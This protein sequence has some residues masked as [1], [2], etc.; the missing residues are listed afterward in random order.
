MAAKDGF[1]PSDPLNEGTISTVLTLFFNGVPIAVIPS[2]KGGGSAAIVRTCLLGTT[3]TRV[4]HVAV[5]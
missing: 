1:D 5:G 4:S 2:A 3:W